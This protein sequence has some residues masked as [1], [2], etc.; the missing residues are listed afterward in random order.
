M[1]GKNQTYG[2]DYKTLS[3]VLSL[4]EHHAYKVKAATYG[5]ALA[6]VCRAALADE[7]TWK[8]AAKLRAAKGEK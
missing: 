1:P 2:K 8:K 3:L 4:E 6:D 7:A 5:V